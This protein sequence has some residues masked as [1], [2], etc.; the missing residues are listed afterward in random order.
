M[1]RIHQFLISAAAVLTAVWTRFSLAV[2]AAGDAAQPTPYQE[3]APQ[4]ALETIFQAALL[5]LIPIVAGGL[6]ALIVVLIVR[7]AI[8]KKKAENGKKD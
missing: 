2:S 1:K 7:A 6:I 4:T 3:H 5:I 8:R